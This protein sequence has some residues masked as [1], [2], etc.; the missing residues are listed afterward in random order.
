[1][2]IILYANGTSENHGC[3]AITYSTENILRGLYQQLYCTTTNLKYEKNLPQNCHWIEYSYFRKPT[4]L[5]RLISKIER[6]TLHSNRFMSS[7]PWLEHV[8]SAFSNC[9]VAL[10]VGGDNYCN[11]S[12]GWLYQLHNK[13]IES[14]LKTVLWGCSVDKHCIDDNLMRE[15]LMKYDIICARE[16]L[17]SQILSSFH[18]N[19]KLYPDPAFTLPFQE[20]AWPG[21]EDPAAG[22]IG[23][24]LSP[25]SMACE[26][27][28]GMT[29]E[30]YKR[31]IEY[32]LKNT[33]YHI[34]LIPHVVF[35]NYY[36]D[37]LELKKL[38]HSYV[39]SKRII[40]I[41]DNN[42]HVMKGYI[43]RCRF[44]IT[45]RTHASIAAY[46]SC[47]PTIVLGYSIKAKG[48]ATDLFGTS[49]NYVLPVQ[50]IWSE[51]DLLENFKWL[52]NNETA[53][54]DRL[55]QMMPSYI[56]RAYDARNEII[57]LGD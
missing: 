34:A 33:S 28:K 8:Y 16:S 47:V 17:T 40:L 53:I 56:E 45:A 49:E 30:N 3:E 25:T 4:I 2:N 42:C 23:L 43:R 52:L 11:G 9:Q 46:S 50:N 27:K 51:T 15:D 54:R 35:Q 10:S 20:L 41:H 7:N 12:Y 57:G 21:D 37:L 55:T 18:P 26:A 19:V 14:G 29:L 22:Y 32:I 5:N 6:T 24:N 48:I 31:V 13:A 1:M 38:Y 36:G 44:F 39:D